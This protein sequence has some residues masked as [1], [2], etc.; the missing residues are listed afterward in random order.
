M[1]ETNTLSMHAGQ[2]VFA[3]SGL[4]T[5][6]APEAVESDTGG[7]FAEKFQT[8]R[9][10]PQHANLRFDDR[11]L[12]ARPR[13]GAYRSRG[14]HFTQSAAAERAGRSLLFLSPAARTRGFL[15]ARKGR[16][17]LISCRSSRNGEAAGGGPDHAATGATAPASNS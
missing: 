9:H 17:L 12:F 11:H 7:I 1:S 13:A 6:R 14:L 15:R 2:E 16:S 8:I 3:A 10:H 5:C 4:V